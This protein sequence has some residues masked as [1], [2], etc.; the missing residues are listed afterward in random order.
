MTEK[1]GRERERECV[2]KTERRKK[3]TGKRDDETLEQNGPF[4]AI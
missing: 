2:T 1:R 3:K 4:E